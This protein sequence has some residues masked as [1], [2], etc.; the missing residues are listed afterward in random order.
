M[1]TKISDSKNH[2]RFSLRCLCKGIVPVSF[3]LKNL[4]RTQKGVSIIHKAEM[5]L[6]N[7]R[8][9]NINNTID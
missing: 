1:E 4:I 9:R 7:E 2:Q 5:K 3:R 8:I 6:L